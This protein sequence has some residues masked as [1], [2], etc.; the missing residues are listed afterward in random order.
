M[1]IWFAV[2]LPDPLFTSPTSTVLEDSD[3]RLLAG[4]IASDGQWRFPM[5]DSLPEKFKLSIIYFEDEYFYQHP[6]FNPVSFGRALKQNIKAK[7]VV[8]GG[9]TL[10]MQTIRLSRKGKSRT[11]FEKLIEVIQAFRME[12][13]FSKEEILR[14]YAAH[15]PFGGNVV[16][17]DAA[18]WRYYG[19]SPHQLS[20]GE[21]TTLAVLPNAPSLV[22]PGKNS[23]KLLKKRNRLLDK[24]HAKG[25]IDEWTCELAKEEPLPGSPHSIPNLTPHLLARAMKE[26]YSGQCVQTTIDRNLQENVNRI[27]NDYHGVLSQNEIHNMAVLIMDVR[28]GNVLAYTGNTDCPDEGSGRAVDVI[29]APR[30]TGSVLKPFL[31]TFMLQDGALLPDQLV[32]DIPTRISGYAPKNFDL[33]YDGAVP[34]SEALARS[35]NIPAVLMLREYGLEQFYH[36]L[37]KLRFSTINRSIDH[38]GLSIILGGAE[39]KL[40]ELGTAYMNM[41]RVLNRDSCL[42]SGTYDQTLSPQ[43]NDELTEAFDPAALW[44]TA[45]AMS[46]L[47][48][49]WQEAGWQ[50]FSSSQKVAWKT[51][52]SFGHRDAWAIGFTPDHLV[53]VWVGNA[54]G[55]G[56]PGLTGLGVA[57]PVLFK[58]FKHLPNS[59]WFEQ[60]QLH[61][62]NV[63]VCKQSGFL[64]SNNCPDR[65]QTHVPE[66][67]VRAAGCPYHQLVHLD[68]TRQFRVSSDCYSVADM[69]T[70]PWFLLPPI[71]EWY[72]RRKNPSYRPLPTYGK[73]CQPNS[74][75]S[76]A[77]IY[78]KEN[79]G[80]FIPRNLDGTMEKVVF[81][82]AHRQPGNT[83][84]WHL[85]ESFVGTTQFEH[86]LEISSGAGIHQLTV[87]DE[88]GESLSWKFEMLEK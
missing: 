28:T 64:A 87:V 60:P 51:G 18:A 54:D 79:S 14:M 76:M 81:E 68:S 33:A 29:M 58:V 34:A 52:T 88:N 39:A 38:Y 42:M 48:R 7:R 72:Y 41:A 59:D 71:Q 2:C 47:N 77:V 21:M 10:S 85:D 45:E 43:T 12:L 26:G 1:T 9:S 27:V 56:R 3:G 4:R 20:W 25:V 35:L 84:H 65:V 32:A 70:E 66:N 16:G 40:W 78:P 80:I 30:S 17:L 50:E 63:E 69:K 24:L 55:E 62:T 57:A 49:P 37:K 83:V 67:A 23:D 13:S 5:A 82:I 6:G 53:G 86:S 36:R 8:S 46:T 15:A 74:E 22:Y 19:R 44:W 11:V 73:H 31:Y 61:M 75:P